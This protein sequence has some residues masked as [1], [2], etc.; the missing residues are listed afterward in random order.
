MKLNIYVLLQYLET[1]LQTKDLEEH[2]FVTEANF[3]TRMENKVKCNT[4]QM[5][6]TQST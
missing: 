5:V 1:I 6:A 2:T 4:P 3:Q